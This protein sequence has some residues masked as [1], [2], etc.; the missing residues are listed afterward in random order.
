MLLNKIKDEELVLCINFNTEA[1]K[2][3]NCSTI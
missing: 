3:I 2:K 1:E